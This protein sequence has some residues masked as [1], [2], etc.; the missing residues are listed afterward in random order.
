MAERRT[1][2]RVASFTAIGLAGLVL[3]VA[4]RGSVALLAI[5]TGAVVIGLLLTGIPLLRDDGI[6]WDWQPK[7][8]DEVPPEPGV[9][10]LRLLLDPSGVDPGAPERLQALVRALAQDRVSTRS[11]G[12]GPDS[13]A[14]GPSTTLTRYLADPPRPLDLDEVDR[15]ITDL[16]SLIPRRTP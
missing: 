6:D 3:A 14:P 4:L 7:R 1:T 8:A 10:R 2:Y 5:A 11:R 15:V 13:P 12:P 9:A 16:E